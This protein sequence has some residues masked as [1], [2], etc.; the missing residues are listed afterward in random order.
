MGVGVG[1][2]VGVSVGVLVG[3][4]VGVNVGVSVGVGVGVLV[5]VLVGVDVGVLVGVSVGVGVGVLV[6]VFVGVLVGDGVDGTEHNQLKREVAN[7]TL[8]EVDKYE[9]SKRFISLRIATL[10]VPHSA[11][12]TS[13]SV[14]GGVPHA[15][16][17]D[18][19]PT[20]NTPAATM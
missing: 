10:E 20:D 9:S 2:D 3:V 6:G 12:E 11:I 13:G 16:S 4:L 14:V 7:C 17:M 15:A 8:S 18:G 5:G 1:V 19:A